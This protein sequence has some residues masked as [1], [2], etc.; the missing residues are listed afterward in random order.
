MFVYAGIDEAGYGP[1]FGPLL[2][3]RMVIAVPKL[4]P[5]AP[6]PPLW[7]RLAKAVCRD[8]SG[9]KG[10]IA[11]NDSKKLHTPASRAP[12]RR[13]TDGWD[14]AA[15]AAIAVEE[16]PQGEA[17]DGALGS[18]GALGARGVSGGEEPIAP[19]AVK[20][21]ERGVLAFAALAGHKPECV[22]SWLDC[23]GNTCH[24]EA[25]ALPWYAPTP[26]CPW[27][28]LPCANTFGEIAV[29]RNLLADTAGRVGVQ[30]LDLGAAVVFEDHFNQMLET[31]RSKAATS[32]TFVGA[33]LRRV[34]D[35]FGHHR[36]TVVVD[37]QGG[38]LRYRELLAM[39]F[40][41]AQLRVVDETEACSEY[42]LWEEAAERSFESRVS[43]FEFRV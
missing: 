23:L 32:F 31:T 19:A 20:H 24:R 16:L 18:D 9:R 6:P 15:G 11:V 10:R 34:W 14:A 12:S 42:R 43:S 4:E 40:P 35:A 26:R 5:D 39:I 41:E 36:P 37:R 29:A 13:G 25:G 8:L 33:H 3:A 27:Q 28:A 2:V 21:L 17:T 22:G 7:Q 38:R 30:V 1:L